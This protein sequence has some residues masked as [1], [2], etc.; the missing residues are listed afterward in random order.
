MAQRE[1][2]ATALRARGMQVYSVPDVA[3]VITAAEQARLV[4][5]L[6]EPALLVREPLDL[7]AQIRARGGY[8][9]AVFALTNS[10]TE[11]LREP[12]ARHG[13]ALIPRAEGDVRGLADWVRE[14]AD[15]RAAN[16]TDGLKPGDH[17]TGEKV[18][19]SVGGATLGASGTPGSKVILVVEDE[20][21][22]RVFLCEAL[23]DAGYEVWAAAN[24]QE[25]LAFFRERTADLVISD[26]N[27]PGMDGFEL[28]Q[29]I[30]NFR[31]AKT[32]FL[33]MTADARR[34]NV[35]DAASMGIVFVMAKPIRN[36]DALYAIVGEALRG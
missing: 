9:T 13:A 33:M 32:P 21:S 35:E 2:L 23:G 7:R 26:V 25:A 8:D 14:D 6:V 20:P 4:I 29:N 1:T 24:G 22:F 5:V 12:L 15:A 28:K 31:G 16:I 36:L 34:D 19:R 18:V 27:M 3:G 11:E 30:D 10:L 17:W